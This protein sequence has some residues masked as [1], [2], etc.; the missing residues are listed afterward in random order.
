M[1]KFD[2]WVWHTGGFRKK[3][4]KADSIVEASRVVKK[5]NRGH[6]GFLIIPYELRFRHFEPIQAYCKYWGVSYDVVSIGR[7]RRD[8]YG[9]G[10]VKDSE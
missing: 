5:K 2:V 7:P 8:L 6:L 10:E 1:A 9:S 3:T 4:V